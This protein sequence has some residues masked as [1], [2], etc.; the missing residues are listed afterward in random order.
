MAGLDPANSAYV[1]GQ[2]EDNSYFAA[3]SFFS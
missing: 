1:V 2:V 3:F